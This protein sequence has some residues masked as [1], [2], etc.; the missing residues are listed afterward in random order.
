MFGSG[1]FSE[2]P[3]SPLDPSL[4]SQGVEHKHIVSSRRAYM[5]HI[6]RLH[7][8]Y[9]YLPSIGSKLLLLSMG[10]KTNKQTHTFIKTTKASLGE[11]IKKYIC[12]EIKRSCVQWQLF[13]YSERDFQTVNNHFVCCLTWTSRGHIVYGAVI[14]SCPEESPTGKRWGFIVM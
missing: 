11:H 14:T 7:L 12:H 1:F 8:C 6:W 4:L 2:T 9:H 3:E 13:F 10:R 5:T